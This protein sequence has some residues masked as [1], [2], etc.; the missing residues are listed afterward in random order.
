MSNISHYEHAKFII[1]RFDYYL[2]IVN[3]KG[4]FY[5][6]LNTFLLGGLFTGIM[7]VYKQIDH[8]LLLWLLLGGFV[9]CSLV[10]IICTIIAINPFL[11][12]GNSSS[13]NRS[14]VFFG[15]VNEFDKAAHASAF[16][17]QDDEAKT[18]DCISQS[19]ILARGMVPKYKRL[20]VA[21]ILLIV[22]FLLLPLVILCI[23]Q[24][25][26]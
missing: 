21:G 19:W 4:T 23:T 11:R 1:G 3:T 22:Q 25:F 18:Q 7:A 5:V 14:L 10:S 6:G 16:V 24:N 15:S 17:A 13:P 2:N 9:L 26:K 8:P 12:S 20:S